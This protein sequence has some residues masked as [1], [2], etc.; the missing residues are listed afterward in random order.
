[1]MLML[2]NYVDV[3]VDPSEAYRKEKEKGK[4]KKAKAIELARQEAI[5]KMPPARQWWSKSRRDIRKY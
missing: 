2:N 1:M 3:V 5:E 4:W